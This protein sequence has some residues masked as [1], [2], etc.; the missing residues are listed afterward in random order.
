[1]REQIAGD[2]L[3]PLSDEMIAATG[4]L[5][6]WI[7]EYNQRDVKTQWEGILNDV[8]DVTGEVVLGLSFGCARC[9][10][11]KFD[12]IL[13]K[14]YYRLQAFFAPMIPRY[15]VPV[16]YSEQ[17]KFDTAVANSQLDK[18]QSL[19]QRIA[20]LESDIRKSTIDATIEKFP[21]EIRP[22]LRK[23][24]S[25]RNAWERQIAQLSFLQIE[26]D[27][28]AIDFSKKLTG[29][30]LEEWK[31]QREALKA[32]E[33]EMPKPPERALTVSDA[34]AEPPETR[35]P[36]KDSVGPVAPGV[37][38]IIHPEPMPIEPIA[39]RSTGRRTALA[40][41]MTD[42][43]NV[44]TWRTIV[45]R[46]WQ[47]HFGRGIVS[48]AS[49]LGK[50]TEPPSHPE[51]LDWLSLWFVE[52]DQSF[53]KLHRLI[54]TSKT[55]RQTAFPAE[56]NV[57]MQIDPDNVWLWRYRSHRLDAEQIRDSMLVATSE[58]DWRSFGPS[59]EKESNRRSIY[60]RAMRN[61]LHAMLASFDRPDGSSSV[62]KRNATNTSLQSLYM[63]NAPWPLARAE[64]L[65]EKIMLE[66][67]DP[68]T[69]VQEAFRHVYL[70]NPSHDELASAVAFVA[71]NM[72]TA[73]V[74]ESSTESNDAAQ[75]AE[76]NRGNT[77]S[78]TR[79]S[80]ADFIHILFSSNE[81][82]YVE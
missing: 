48:N 11:H 22:A 78:I 47:H 4:Y 81:F 38:S 52:N 53:K 77:T 26:N 63:T 60:L 1:L 61:N 44:L 9:H 43:T 50:L 65:S 57:A 40:N 5:R 8:T 75:F 73:S 29:N 16:S 69:A 82:L 27:L 7:Y 33:K 54:M 58:I 30:Q 35:I 25:E 49:D 67:S 20:E 62:A 34:S 72:D 21:P 68:A 59:D 14:D 66:T 46:L 37:L 31:A 80:L 3:D 24:E 39:G 45:N 15:D 64:A 32:L 74:S 12:P 17:A 6:L 51:L 23:S 41:W 70:R 79:Q 2:E 18:L 13:Q 56:A 71:Q 28:S 42:P 36:G 76:P 55:Y 10:D 19:R